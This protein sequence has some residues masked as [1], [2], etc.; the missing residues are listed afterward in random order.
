MFC[1]LHSYYCQDMNLDL[2]FNHLDSLLTPS[3]YT[4]SL[5]QSV[6]E[7]NAHTKYNYY[8][9]ATFFRDIYTH[10]ISLTGKSSEEAN[11]IYMN[12]S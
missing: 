12:C 7:C 10:T 8:F 3:R 11:H 9:L 5:E 4:K 1:E 6:I 2:I